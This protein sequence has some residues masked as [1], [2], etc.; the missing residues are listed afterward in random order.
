MN[1][2]SA[3]LARKYKK[4]KYPP[5]A[6][7]EW[8]KGRGEVY[9]RPQKGLRGGWKPC[10]CLFVSHENLETASKVLGQVTAEWFGTD[11]AVSNG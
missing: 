9:H 11:R 8:C 3:H 6:D 7:C 4:A 5:R 10:M 1:E 2:I